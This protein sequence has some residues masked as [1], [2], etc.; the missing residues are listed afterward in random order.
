MY[1]KGVLTMM[2][3]RSDEAAGDENLSPSLL[4]VLSAEIAVSVSM[5][6]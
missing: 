3:L 6:F 5:I 2:K 4:E 1:L